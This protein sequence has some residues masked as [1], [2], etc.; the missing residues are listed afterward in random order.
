M[1]VFLETHST[2]F[3][4]ELL[5]PI[6]YYCDTLEVIYKLNKIKQDLEVINWWYKGIDYDAF[7]IMYTLIP[8]KITFHNVYGHQKK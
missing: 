4:F 5:Y 1:L 7:R 3:Q 6:K 8:E 2:Y